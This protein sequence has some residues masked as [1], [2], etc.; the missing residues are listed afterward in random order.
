MK[1]EI[2]EKA[3]R[4]VIKL[5]SAVVTH[6]EFGLDFEILF[7]LGKSVYQLKK[8]GIQV[9]LVS[10]GAIAC[11][12]F[13]ININKPL[14]SLSEKQALASLGQSLLMQIYEEIFSKYKLTTAQILLTAEDLAHRNRYLNAIKTL[15][16]LLKWGVVPI[17]NENDTV[18]TEEIN[19]G[20]NDI[21]SA[22][23][24]G[25]IE[26]DLLII[27]SDVEALFTEDPKE[28]PS[29]QRIKEVF[30]VNEE[31]FK[32]ASKKPGKLGR[33]GM[34]SKVLAAK[35]VTSM[36]IPMMLLPGKLPGVIDKLWNN[37]DIG[38]FFHPKKRELPMRK[39]WIKY[40]IKP[41]G[42]I[43]IDE[44]AEQAITKA[45]KSLLIAGVYKVEGDF[46]KGACVECVNSRNQP[47]AKGLSSFSSFEIKEF[48]NQG[49]K[50]DKELIHRDNLV[51]LD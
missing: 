38:T 29:A 9:V 13:K 50:T 1:K 24:A 30:E 27:L 20:D 45:G 32:I 19:F 15:N 25:A 46:S 8:R 23:V 34:Y 40:Y 7:S 17:I 6:E 44:G 12:K 5:G 37:E 10:S 33:G 26:A 42:K 21:L 31:I 51:L 2:L 35:M 16:I 49:K 28:N 39:F 14:L 4:I 36:G 43:Y 18:S 3:K 41:E 11:G 48:L 47:I 22:L